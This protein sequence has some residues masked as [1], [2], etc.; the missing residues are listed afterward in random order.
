MPFPFRHDIGARARHNPASGPVGVTATVVLLRS[1]QAPHLTVQNTNAAFLPLAAH[2]SF[3]PHDKRR[4]R[5]RPGRG[6]AGPT[7]KDDIMD[8]LGHSTAGNVRVKTPCRSVRRMVPG[9]VIAVS[10]VLVASWV[11]LAKADPASASPYPE[12]PMIFELDIPISP[13]GLG[14]LFAHDLTDDGRMDF[15]ITAPGHVAAYSGAGELLWH[16]QDDISLDRADE[17]Y[18]YPGLH[19]PGAIAGDGDGDGREEVAYLLSDGTLNIRDGRTGEIERRFDFPGALALS[20]ANFRGTGERDAV[21][22]YSQREPRAISLED[23]TT[24]WHVTDWWGIEHSMVRTMD[25]DGDGG[26][27]VLGPVLLDHDG[28]ALVSVARKGTRM[29]AFD[30]LAVG[31]LLPEPGLEIALAE[32]HGNQETIV[33]GPTGA[34]W[35]IQHEPGGVRAIGECRYNED[36]DKLA[37][38]DFD[39]TRPGQEV[40]ARSSC[41]NHPSVMGGDGEVIASWSVRRTAPPGWCHVG[42]CRADPD[43]NFLRRIADWTRVDFRGGRSVWRGEYGID[44]ARPVHWEGTGRQ[45]LFVTER[46]VHGQIAL[47]DA[48]TGR[49]L[50][51]WPAQAARTYAADVAG[52]FREELVVLEARAGGSTPEI[53]RKED[54]ADGLPRA[55]LWENQAYRRIRQTWN[56]NS[57]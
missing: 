40:F 10:L 47:V 7:W 41:G 25:L 17:G 15:A 4:D 44:I 29:N 55:R 43:V 30:S 37:V 49:F 28:T 36:A 24:L 6:S 22:Q 21:F 14:A 26:D 34:G 1:P 50:R 38:G 12:N 2:A 5:L 56:Y 20:M 11:P 42:D 54:A 9:T 39:T 33:L 32:Q 35:A 51:V 48:S 46:H 8:W 45:L 16:V 27:E 31:D 19:A 53:L 3:A 57:P 18:G 23:G 52:D 13:A